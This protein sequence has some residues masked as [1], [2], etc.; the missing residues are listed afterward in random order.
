MPE[1]L[2]ISQHGEWS[3]S[4]RTRA[5]QYL[6]AFEQEFDTVLT[7]IPASLPARKP[8][9]LGQ[10]AYFAHHALFY[11]K[12]WRRIHSCVKSADVIFIQRALYGLGPGW[13]TRPIQRSRGRVVLDLDD[14]L[15]V[16]TPAMRGK[17]ALAQW[18]YGPQ[19]VKRIAER[20]DEIIV[21]TDQLAHEMAWTEK[22]IH[23]IP[24][25]PDIGRYPQSI[26]SVDGP[27]QLVWAGT[28]GGLAYLDFLSDS[29]TR[30]QEQRIGELTVI[31][32]EPWTGPSRF[33]K[34]KQEGEESRLA[35]F[36][37]GIMPLPDTEYARSKA[38]YKLLQYMATGMPV[39]AS[40]VGINVSLLKD[41]Q[42]GFLCH[43]ADEWEARIRELHSHRQA[44][45]AMGVLGREFVERYV[46]QANT[47]SRIRDIVRVKDQ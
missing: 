46:E 33:I 27:L 14:N 17:G 11:L 25:L 40:P 2:L 38:G 47:D 16:T 41:S 44:A 26:M 21:S 36:D 39:L 45:R 18:L 19:Q 15:F 37:V 22:P 43:D 30:L 1:L 8:G 4:T 6:S 24:T 10:V 31:C 7:A 35:S 23:V 5:L 20:A 12:Q 32:S 28:R 13:I 34:W 42:A 9:R 29:L 3:A